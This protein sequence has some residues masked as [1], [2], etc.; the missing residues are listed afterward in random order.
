[1]DDFEVMFRIWPHGVQETEEYFVLK[2]H[3]SWAPL[4]A[5]QFKE[6]ITS[7]FFA[8]TRFFRVIDHFM[9]Q[10]G[11]SPDPGTT[12]AWQKREIKDDPVKHKNA[13]GTITY[14]TSGPN[15][16]ST[17]LFINFKDN[18]YLDPQGFAP[19][20]EIVEGMDVVGG[21]SPDWLFLLF[22]DSCVP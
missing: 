21:C 2:I 14:G 8:G 19:I 5:A 16:R 22:F 4:G 1:M 17:Q 10:F 11:I 18:S 7:G 3:P 15:S 20:G 13:R 12:Q 9:A 6:L